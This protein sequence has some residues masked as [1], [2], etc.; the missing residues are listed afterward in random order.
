MASSPEHQQQPK[1]QPGGASGLYRAPT[2]A[3]NIDFGN[4]F[5]LGISQGPSVASADASSSPTMSQTWMPSSPTAI[6]N[7]SGPRRAPVVGDGY[8]SGPPSASS[9]PKASFSPRMAPQPSREYMRIPQPISVRSHSHTRIYRQ[10]SYCNAFTQQTEELAAI[11][12]SRR[13]QRRN[14]NGRLDAQ[15][16]SCGSL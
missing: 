6:S 4:S 12:H 9:S 1:R 13:Q 16:S 7:S 8:A 2:W 3:R 10:W 5:D 11:G 15:S 14:T